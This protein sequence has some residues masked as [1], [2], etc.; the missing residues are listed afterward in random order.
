VTYKS[1]VDSGNVNA[2]IY[3][4]LHTCFGCPSDNVSSTV[5]PAVFSPGEAKVCT[6]VVGGLSPGVYTLLTFATARDGSAISA[7]LNEQFQ[8]LPGGSLFIGEASDWV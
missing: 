1:A 7:T 5:I 4:V 6:F 2:T 3:L 8:I